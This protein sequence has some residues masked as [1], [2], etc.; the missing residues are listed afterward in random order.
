MFM[1]DLNFK[2]Y[3]PYLFLIIG[4]GAVMYSILK[5]PSKQSNLKSSGEK[6]E[7]VVYQLG[8]TPDYTPD[9]N[10][11]TNVKDKVTIRFVTKKDEWI[12]ANIDQPFAIFYTGQY[13]G[14][15]KVDVYYDRDNPSNFFVDTK[16]SEK[17]GRI[18]VALIGLV[19]C[20]VG[21]YMFYTQ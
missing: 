8:H 4:A 6:A 11:A 12:T 1:D 20:S 16:Q 15:K 17:L 5:K 9:Y 10:M 21:L 7:G 3:E 18:I 13:K 2:Q 14:A 19:F